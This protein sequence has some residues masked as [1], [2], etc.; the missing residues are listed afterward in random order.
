LDRD[1]DYCPEALN[2]HLGLLEAYA[3]RPEAMAEHIQ[4]LHTMPCPEY[5]HVY[6]DHVTICMI[7]REHQL[8][9]IAGK[10]P[11]VLF[12]CMPR[13]A[14]ATLTYALAKLSRT[15]IGLSRLA[16]AARR[17]D[18]HTKRPNAAYDH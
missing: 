18:K 10:M 14:S 13:S 17:K 15:S 11:A 2:F 3:G 7:T 6:S 9:A 4:L 12:G 16:I 8:Y 1:E 5:E